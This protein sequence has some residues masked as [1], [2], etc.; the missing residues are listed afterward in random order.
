[1]PGWRA[2]VPEGAVALFKVVEKFSIPGAT[3]IKSNVIVSCWQSRSC[4]CRGELPFGYTL[5]HCSGASRGK[6]NFNSA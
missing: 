3:V 1:V 5:V 2:K 4:H 6:S